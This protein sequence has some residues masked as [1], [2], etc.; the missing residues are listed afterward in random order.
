MESSWVWFRSALE[1]PSVS[2]ESE[3]EDEEVEEALVELLSEAT[4]AAA[5][6]ADEGM[7]CG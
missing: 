3:D 7:N 6:A 1:L 5:T 4:A 2:G